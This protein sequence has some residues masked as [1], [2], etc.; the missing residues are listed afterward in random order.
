LLKINRGFKPIN[1]QTTTAM[2]V[3]KDISEGN[4]FHKTKW[5]LPIYDGLTMFLENK[6]KTKEIS[7]YFVTI[8]SNSRKV[9]CIFSASGL[10]ICTN[11][12]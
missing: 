12:L 2:S 1:N 11:R 7:G 4:P 3:H 10:M 5:L 8:A 9:G 6:I